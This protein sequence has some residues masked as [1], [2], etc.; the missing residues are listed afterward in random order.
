MEIQC[1][2][3]NYCDFK[4]PKSLSVLKE[5]V[6]NLRKKYQIFNNENSSERGQLNK[7]SLSFNMIINIFMNSFVVC[8]TYYFVKIYRNDMTIYSFSFLTSWSWIMSSESLVFYRVIYLGSFASF[9][10]N[11]P[12][13]EKRDGNA[14]WPTPR[15]DIGG[16][17]SFK[18]EESAKD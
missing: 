12:I 17:L 6:Q 13:R 9:A 2:P 14:I 3:G 16:M 18:T 10:S 1:F 4:Y 5:I 11:P 15:V 7:F 8:C